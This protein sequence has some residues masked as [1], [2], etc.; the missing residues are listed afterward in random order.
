MK[1]SQF[2]LPVL[3]LGLLFG[4]PGIG[5]AG[6]MDIAEDAMKKISQPASS[7]SGGSL[8]AGLSQDEMVRGLKEALAVGFKKAISLLGKNGGYLDD[9]NVKIP[10]PGV[11]AH[12]ETALGMAGQGAVADRFIETMN[13]AAEQAVPV[14]ADIFSQAIRDMSL[15]DAANILNGPEDAA[16]Q[17]F[18]KISGEQLIRSIQPIVANATENVGLTAAYKMLTG[19]LPKQSGFLSAMVDQ[20]TLDLDGYVTRK[21]MDGLFLKLAK[22]EKQI[23]QNP[24]ARGSDLLKKVFGAVN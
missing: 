9:A 14:T 10:M 23:R 11:L 5:K 13:R 18:R 22:E 8:I 19:T 21:A 17:Y 1:R 15:K 6:W 20:E 7:G 16:T 12:V 24:M 3:A 4:N 2:V